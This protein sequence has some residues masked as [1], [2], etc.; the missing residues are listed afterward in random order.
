[1][2]FRDP[3]PDRSEELRDAAVEVLATAFWENADDPRDHAVLESVVAHARKLVDRVDDLKTAYLVDWVAQYDYKRGAYGLAETL[4]RREW[5]TTRRI[6]ES[7]HPDTLISMGNLALTLHKQGVVLAGARE[8]EEEVLEITRRIRG[9]EHPSTLTMMN[10]LATTLSDQGE[11]EKA[12]EI[13]EE[14]LE[15]RRRILGGEHPDTSVSAWN[16][17]H[18]L[19]DLS[20]SARART[21]LENDLLWLLDRDPAS[22]G[23]DQ[24]QIRDMVSQIA[25]AAE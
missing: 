16:L 2:R 22:L 17:F 9:S 5:E 8:I 6:L 10:N 21:V 15:T 4:Y 19:H 3:K 1:M 13:M 23:A 18:I 12:R 24:R 14:V 11:L 20:D 7:E 25:G